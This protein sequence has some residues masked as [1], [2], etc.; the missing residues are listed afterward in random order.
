[1]LQRY[2]SLSQNGTTVRTE[3][4]AGI[5]SFLATMYIIVVNPAILSQSGMPFGG[6]LTAT[7]FF[8]FSVV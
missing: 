6:V 5:S 3:I 8:L 4:I 2:F 1:M 7:F